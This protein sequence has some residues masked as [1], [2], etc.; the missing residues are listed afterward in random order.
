MLSKGREGRV[1]SYITSG[2]RSDL[3]H[4]LRS[5]HAIVAQYTAV[6]VEHL[7]DSEPPDTAQGLLGRNHPRRDVSGV[8]Y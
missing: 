7:Y 2:L 3:P 6:V 8:V 1:S 4:T 5:G